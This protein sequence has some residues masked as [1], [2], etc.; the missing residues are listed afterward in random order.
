MK[1][2]DFRR[3]REKRLIGASLTVLIPGG[4][5]DPARAINLGTNRWAFKPEIAITRRWQPGLRRAMAG[6]GYTQTTLHTTPVIQNV[7]SILCR[8]SKDILVI[9]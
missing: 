7:H 1:L 4:Q 3:W 5:Y 9:T 8:P 6:Y 2:D